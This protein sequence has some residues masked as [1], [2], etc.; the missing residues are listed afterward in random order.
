MVCGFREERSDTEF[1]SALDGFRGLPL[2]TRR[3]E[4]HHSLFLLLPISGARRDH[5]SFLWTAYVSRHPV[6]FL[7]PRRTNVVGRECGIGSTSMITKDVVLVF[8][9]G[10]TA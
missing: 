3:L 5:A 10:S 8:V 2:F 7:S 6:M 1:S 4:V 9:G